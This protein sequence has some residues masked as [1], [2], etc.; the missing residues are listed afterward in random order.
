MNYE[1][2]LKMAR[3]HAE[4]DAQNLHPPGPRRSEFQRWLT[5][6]IYLDY[7]SPIVVD[8]ALSPP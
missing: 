1:A 3:E 8:E 4:R 2:L 6:K 7:I 5:V